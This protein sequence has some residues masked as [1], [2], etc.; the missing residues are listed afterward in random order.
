[1]LFRSNVGP[2]TGGGEG[3]RIEEYDWNGTLV[4]T[5]D[6]YSATYIAHHDFTVLP[7]GNVIIIASEKKSY[8]EVIAAGFNP[9]LLDPSVASEGYMLPDYVIEVQPTR[10]VGGTVVWEWH[11][12]DHLIQDFDATKNNYG[13]VANHPELVDPNG[14]GGRVQQ[15]WNH[16]NGIDYNAVLDQIMISVRGNSELMVIDHGITRTQ[17]ATHAGGRYGK[18]GDILYRWGYAQQYDRGTGND[19]KLYQQH[20]THWIEPGLPSAGNILIFNNGLGRG[21]SSV[22]EIVPPA[23]SSGA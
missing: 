21:Y 5:I 20:H 15:F 14:V 3:G 22:D 11:I 8:A 17:A 10:P 2:S 1:M 12:W 7:N 13:V 18:G 19:R 9:A 16:V 6:Y 4:W 23:S